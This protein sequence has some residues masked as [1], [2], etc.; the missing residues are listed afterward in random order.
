MPVVGQ[1][2]YFGAC[3][4]AHGDAAAARTGERV[5]ETFSVGVF[6][7][8]PKKRRG[9]KPGPV[10]V[11]VRGLTSNP[12]AVYRRAKEVCDELDSGAYRGPK[13]ITLF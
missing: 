7:W 9:L 5:A 8:R 13:T 6:E 12:I 1:H 10:K 3:D 11:R 4:P 2:D